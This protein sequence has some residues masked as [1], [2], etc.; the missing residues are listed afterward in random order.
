VSASEVSGVDI[1]PDID[2]SQPRPLIAVLEAKPGHADELRA[3]IVSLTCENRREPGCV[4]F[5]P[6]EVDRIPG[7]F[8]LYEI[9][10][11]AEAFEGHLE[12]DHVK[13]FRTALSSVSNSGPTDLAQLVEI[14]VP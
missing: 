4:A 11:D 13:Q 10:A 6:Y 14:A 12:M 2:R 8:F 5:I 7:K 9:F 1:G 3:M